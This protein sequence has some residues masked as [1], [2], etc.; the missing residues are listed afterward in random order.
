MNYYSLPGLL[1]AAQDV[2]PVEEPPE[3]RSHSASDVA[4]VPIGAAT[5]RADSKK[6]WHGMVKN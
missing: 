6:G 4:V 2:S 3:T 1:L 5:C